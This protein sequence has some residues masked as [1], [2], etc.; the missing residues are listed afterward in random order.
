MPFRVLQRYSAGREVSP[1]REL[2]EQCT[3]MITGSTGAF[4]KL[5]FNCFEA[6]FI[7]FP[8]S[9]RTPLG[10][11][12]S[13][14]SSRQPRMW[15]LGEPAETEASMQERTGVTESA[16]EWRAEG[17]W[18]WQTENYKNAKMVFDTERKLPKPGSVNRRWLRKQENMLSPRKHAIDK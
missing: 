3:E 11:N 9:K 2:P 1:R 14:S 8:P 15:R 5:G 6:T 10:E 16:G 12:C 4:F 17:N 18:K 13:D 7:K